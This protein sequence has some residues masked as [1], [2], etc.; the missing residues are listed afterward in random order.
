MNAV[1]D[2][3]TPMSDAVLPASEAKRTPLLIRLWPVWLIAAGLIAAWRFGLFDLLSLD[4]LRDQREG[5]RAFVSANPILAVAAFI[6][7]YA[8]ATLFMIPGALWITISG[9]FLFGLIGGSLATIAGATLGASTLFFAARTSLGG[10]LRKMAGPWVG[11][12]EEEF[13][14]DALSYM[15]AMRFIPAMP[16][17]VSNVLPALLGAK[18]RDYLITTALGIIPGVVA[19]TWIGAGLGATFDAGGEPDLGSI[20]KNLIPAGIALALVSLLPVALKRL[21]RTKPEAAPN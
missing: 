1:P 13:R 9:G 10:G 8:L 15:F 7:I 16:F 14:K 18:Y 17:P 21:K 2:E 19:Y 20:A 12:V 4:T 3:S 5:L 11:K 6:G